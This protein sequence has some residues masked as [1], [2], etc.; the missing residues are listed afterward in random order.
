MYGWDLTSG[1]IAGIDA[2]FV[3]G[4][5][6]QDPAGMGKAAIESLVKITAG[7]PVEKVV[8]VPATIV[9]KENVDQFRDMFK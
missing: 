1:V 9:T 4:V 6:Q 8:S 2:G 5:V 3:G 7:E